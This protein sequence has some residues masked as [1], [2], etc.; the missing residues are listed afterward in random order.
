[1]ITL[2]RVIPPSMK[3]DVDKQREIVLELAH[4]S[5]LDTQKDFEIDVEIRMSNNVIKPTLELAKEGKYD[6]LVVGASER[7]HVGKILFGSIAL[8]LAEQA[9]CPV[10]I[11]RRNIQH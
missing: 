1:M 2:L 4:E 5:L 8:T 3:M 9:P 10:I 7:S 11:V 6:L